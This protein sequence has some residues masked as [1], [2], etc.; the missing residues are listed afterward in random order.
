MGPRGPQMYYLRENGASWALVARDLGTG[1]ERE[2]LTDQ[3]GNLRGI[4]P[5]PDGKTLALMIGGDGSDAVFTMD[6]G[7][8]AL[9]EVHRGMYSGASQIVWTPDNRYFFFYFF[10][11]SWDGDPP[12][13]RLW[14]GDAATGEVV[15]M[16]G[17]GK[18]FHWVQPALHP[19]G[20][21]I[22]FVGGT[23]HGEVWMMTD[24]PG[25]RN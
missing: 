23:T 16:S 5:S 11:L 7:G 14:R 9:R 17:H 18:A 3:P 2:I 12:A 22:A 20:R 25:G 13:N 24:L 15:R 19:G 4:R 6:A 8:G 21:R 1:S 10:F